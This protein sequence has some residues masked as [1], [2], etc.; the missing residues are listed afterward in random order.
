MKI[1]IGQGN[2]WVPLEPAFVKWIQLEMVSQT[3]ANTEVSGDT[4][5]YT[6]ADYQRPRQTWDIAWH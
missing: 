3:A 2:A 5:L 6:F 1:S 4:S